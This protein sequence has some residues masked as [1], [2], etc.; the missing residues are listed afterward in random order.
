MDDFTR[1]RLA[2]NE[3][4][5]RAVNEEIEGR[6]GG[7]V[8]EYVCECAD[9]ECAV[10]VRLSAAQYRDVRSAPDRFVV[11]PGHERLELERVVG[12][13]DGYLVVEK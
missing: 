3:E 10:T 12:S 4:L 1:R 13:H 8:T 6:S 5:F 11:V 9:P 2:R 7:G